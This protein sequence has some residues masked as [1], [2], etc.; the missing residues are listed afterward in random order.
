MRALVTGGAGFI[1][2]HLTDRLLADGW[3]VT[4]VDN[5]STGR[6]ANLVDARHAP[7]GSF[8]FID[9]D[10]TSPSLEHVLRAVRPD[11]VFH[12]AAQM[13][14][15]VSVREPARDCTTNVVGTVNLL[16]ACAAAAVRRV[17][18]ASS[19]GCIYGPPDARPVSEDFR[20]TPHS[21]YGASKVAAEVYLET[22]RVMT[23]L[24]YVALALG[25][26]YGP[27]Q[28]PDGEAGVVAIF[29]TALLQGKPTRIFGDGSSSRDY[30]YVGDVVDAFVRAASRG[31]CRR[32]NVATGIPT[33][34]R[35]L[36]TRIATRLDVPDE[37]A[38]VPART[39]EL[40]AISLDCAAASA[41]L[42]WHAETVLDAGLAH[43][44]SWLRRQT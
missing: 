3:H 13:D 33:T 30:V 42:G 27:R 44:L 8:H 5:L 28:A 31:R 23:G 21:P 32:Y 4:I 26:V 9:Q 14:V 40:Q 7:E 22:F 11:V 39:G 12:L 17:V 19:G 43:T 29:G 38:M 6:W 10:I 41:E 2:S 25:N 24:E 16:A 35:E 36:H 37:P 20:T 34:I 1:G 15:R 18:F